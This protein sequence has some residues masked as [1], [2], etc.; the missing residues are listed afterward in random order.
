[1]I[2]ESGTKSVICERAGQSASEVYGPDQ[3][4]TGPGGGVDGNE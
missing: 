3:M 4:G 2:L 1:M